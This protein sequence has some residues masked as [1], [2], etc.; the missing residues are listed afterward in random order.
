MAFRVFFL[1]TLIQSLFITVH[2]WHF[3]RPCT[4]QCARSNRWPC[5][6]CT[7]RPF[8]FL[9]TVC[10][11]VTSNGVLHFG[12]LIWPGQVQRLDKDGGCG[13]TPSAILE[14]FFCHLLQLLTVA[15]GKWKT[16]IISSPFCDLQWSPPGSKQW[17]LWIPSR[18]MPD[19]SNCQQI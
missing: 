12:I 17:P 4:L 16:E 19:W 8:D 6:W 5:P 3:L 18:L 7:L 14:H 15:K 1:A 10:L 11:Q 9:S 13:V 2:L